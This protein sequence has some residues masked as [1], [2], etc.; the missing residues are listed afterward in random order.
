MNWYEIAKG[1]LGTTEIAGPEHNPRIV[2]YQQATSLGASDDETPWCASFVNWCLQQAGI[3]GTN[4]AA[5]RSFLNWGR[6]IKTPVEGCI[7]VL[8]RGNSSWQGH[9]GFYVGEIGDRVNLLGGNQGNKVSIKGYKKEDILGYRLPKRIIDSKT[10]ATSTAGAT[11]VA[12]ET[13]QQAMP[14]IQDAY[15]LDS[16]LLNKF[17]P[18]AVGILVV[19][20]FG[21]IIYERVQKIK[22][23]QI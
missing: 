13:Y 18:I 15:M 6:E 23:R 7:V 22:T 16:D 17:L 9:V 20:M 10:V 4:S 21:Y 3:A 12:Y 11:A 5:A 2:E 19:G 14:L 8:K 1:E